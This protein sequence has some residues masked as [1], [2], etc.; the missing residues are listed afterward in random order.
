[1]ETN[2]KKEH[3]HEKCKELF[4]VLSE[5]IDKELDKKDAEKIKAHLESCE[6]C[7][8]C[9]SSLKKTIE[10]CSNFFKEK[11]VPETLS[12]RLRTIAKNHGSN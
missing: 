8:D 10:I 4:S 7:N 5:Y 12:E 11:K 2:E 6:C 9:V 3:D 1:M